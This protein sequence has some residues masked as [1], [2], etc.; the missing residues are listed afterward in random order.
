M[1]HDDRRARVE[2]GLRA[3]V[4]VSNRPLEQFSLVERMERYGVPGASIAVVDDGEVAWSAGY[5]SISRGS[6]PV[7]ADTLFQAA[8][9]SKAVAAVG[10]L[11][12]AERGVIDLDAD[13]NSMLRSWRLPESA[14]TDGSPVTV[15]HLLCHRAGLTV[16]GFPGYTDDAA[17]AGSVPDA[18]GVLDG[19]GNTPAVESFAVP[20]TVSQYSGGG[21]TIVQVLVG[22]VTG[23][24]FAEVMHELVLGPLGM[25]ESAYVQPLPE[26]RRHRAAIGHGATGEP[27][28]GGAHVYPELQAAGLWTTAVDL[29]RW[30]LGVQAM[31]R[32]EAGPLSQH[33]AQQMVSPVDGGPFGLGPETGGEGGYRRFGHSGANEGFRSQMDALVERPV[34]AVVLTNA[35]AGTALCAEVR[36]SFAAEYDWGDVGTTTVEIADVDPA[37]LRSYA[38]RYAGPFDRPMRLEYADGELFSPAPYG[39][40]RM[41]PIGPTSLIDEETGALL[42]VRHAADDAGADTLRIAVMVNGA[43]LM[44]FTRVG[45]PR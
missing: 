26:A 35:D 9:V 13:V 42:E 27:V 3:L 15:R 19:R 1:I 17:S 33:M 29:A 30:L 24:P 11:A 44:G 43:E 7:H 28:P 8:S 14:H 45:G 6:S 39:R 41:L 22:D 16:P 4:Q 18:V 38:G 23:R 12:L 10:V 2:H 40:R 20:G 34:G 21:S 32:G 36:R 25:A 37:V 5:G 31:L